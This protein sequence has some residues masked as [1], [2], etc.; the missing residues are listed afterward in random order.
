L[1]PTNNE[2]KKDGALINPEK[3]GVRRLR[4][5]APYWQKGVKAARGPGVDDLAVPVAKPIRLP[6]GGPPGKGVVFTLPL[7]P[8]SYIADNLGVKKT[9]H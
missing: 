7:S 2:E 8:P 4:W 6:K 3:K 9:N 5:G 1:A